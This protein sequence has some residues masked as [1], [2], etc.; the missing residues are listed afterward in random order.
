MAIQNYVPDE[1]RL[2]LP[3]LQH[4]L[5]PEGGRLLAA[6]GEVREV[7]PA[8]I[9]K[10]R[11]N[12]DA[13][14]VHAA[15]TIADVRRRAGGPKGKFA[16][17]ADHFFAPPEALEQA[18]SLAI[19][20]Y[21]ARAL[22]HQPELHDKAVIVDFCAGIGGDALAFAA[23]APTIAIEM[24]PVRAWCLS[25]NAAATG[26][27]LEIIQDD[28][29]CVLPTLCEQLNHR[30]PDRTPIF[31]I[32]PARRSGGK[33]SHAWADMIPGPE[34]INQ[35][36]SQFAGGMIKLS[37]AADFS[38]LPVGHL[39][40]ISD[41]RHAVQALLWV[42]KLAEYFPSGT[43]TATIVP[44]Q[45]E[46]WSLTAAPQLP[47]MPQAPQTYLYEVDPAVHR[48]GLAPALADQHQLAP[49]NTDGGYL[50][51]AAHIRLPA[52]AAFEHITTVLFRDLRRALAALPPGRPGPVEVK[53][54]G[55]LD[56]DPDHL[57]KELSAITPA[58]CT[59]MIYKNDESTVAS[60]CQRISA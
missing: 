18:T 39:E 23:V 29:L 15:L 37:P 14:Q 5:T 57:Q 6:A 1:S 32:D 9:Q 11:K 26:V 20:R 45:G 60:L 56:L 52:L 3:A 21:K 47:G 33:R 54:R 46:S 19:A 12:A 25:Q 16:E 8:A 2:S 58:A 22:N 30:H 50:T 48:A 13:Q 59:V 31:H 34:V 51:G 49:L 4:L 10:L 42:G 24:S 17:I 53:T 40:L 36:I 43:R 55:G 38:E 28:M 27:N 35:I 7:T 41:G 44:P